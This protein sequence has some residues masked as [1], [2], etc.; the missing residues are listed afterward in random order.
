MLIHYGVQEMNEL[1]RRLFYGIWKRKNKS[2]QLGLDH[3]EPLFL[4][5]E[6]LNMGIKK[7]KAYLVNSQNQGKLIPHFILHTEDIDQ[8]QK[9]R[10]EEQEEIA[11]KSS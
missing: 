5:L 6:H 3:H 10:I 4:A 8:S 11:F 7:A 1:D 2:I 9:S